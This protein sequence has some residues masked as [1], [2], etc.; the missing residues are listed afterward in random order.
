MELIYIRQ[1]QYKLFY[2]II[3]KIQPLV[4]INNAG[5]ASVS[6]S[7]E[8]QAVLP[9]WFAAPVVISRCGR[10]A[11]TDTQNVV[12]VIVVVCRRSPPFVVA[13]QSCTY[14]WKVGMES[15]RVGRSKGAG[16][17]VLMPCPA[18]RFD[19]NPTTI[20][21]KRAQSVCASFHR[22]NMQ[23]K[24]SKKKMVCL[25]YRRGK[26]GTHPLT[27]CTPYSFLSTSTATVAS[28]IRG[29]WSSA[30]SFDFSCIVLARLRC[31]VSDIGY[32]VWVIGYGLW[33]MG[34]SYQFAYASEFWRRAV[35]Q[36]FSII[37]KSL[38]EN[39][40]NKSCA[41]YNTKKLMIIR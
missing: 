17:R 31:W 9:S 41:D 4:I 25:Y 8:L 22:L 3:W 37:F 19:H 14:M 34:Y 16:I 30:A 7:S 15:R 6:E 32:G 33:V 38:A 2:K 35:S 11:D 21:R 13:A 36:T 24:K 12:V 26:D 1:L 29:L 18:N 5:F 39:N 27:E 23:H 40:N 28:G 10:A 20:S